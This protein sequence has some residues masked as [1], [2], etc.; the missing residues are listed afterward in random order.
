MYIYIYKIQTKKVTH[1]VVFK[2]KKIRG[3]FI[4]TNRPFSHRVCLFC[5]LQHE[6]L[7][8]FGRRDQETT[9]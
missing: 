7:T 4:Q 6:I 9:K 5:R 3:I 2:G 8:F 1:E